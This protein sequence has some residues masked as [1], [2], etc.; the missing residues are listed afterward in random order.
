MDGCSFGAPPFRVTDIKGAIDPAR[1]RW[2]NRTFR[3]RLKDEAP[4]GTGLG[5][6]SQGIAPYAPSRL[7]IVPGDCKYISENF[8]VF[9]PGNFDL[10]G[11]TTAGS[12]ED[13]ST[14]QARSEYHGQ[15]SLYSVR[16]FA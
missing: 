11:D 2:S 4:N 10:T 12:P 15:E 7:Y 5:A 3:D 14:W 1:A 13:A 6:S 8:R 9:G 16:T